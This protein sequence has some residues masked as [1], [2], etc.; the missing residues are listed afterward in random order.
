V[1]EEINKAGGR[2][3]RGPGNEVTKISLV[4]GEGRGY[5]LGKIK[6]GF[7]NLHTLDLSGT[8]CAD[9]DL[10][11]LEG[12]ANLKVLR[13]GNHKV[14]SGGMQFLKDMKGLEELDLGGTLVH[15][16]GLEQLKGLKNLKKLV[17]ANAPL[18]TGRNL[19]GAIPGLEIIR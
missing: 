4:G 1:L 3:E 15:D 19:E 18:A 8:L 9:I 17:L 6:D 12:W 2:V 14:T 7:P 13:L 11:H 5:I 10:E 16:G